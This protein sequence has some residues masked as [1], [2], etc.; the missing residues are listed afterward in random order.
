MTYDNSNSFQPHEHARTL[1]SLGGRTDSQALRSD[2]KHNRAGDFPLPGFLLYKVRSPRFDREPQ[3]IG[4]RAGGSL[5]HYSMIC[6]KNQ[7]MFAQVKIDCYYRVTTDSILVYI[8][9]EMKKALKPL[10]HN[11]FKTFSFGDP[12]EIRTPDTLI[13]SQV[14]YRLS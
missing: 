5:L 1:R 14:L 9:I 11:D 2:L 3:E 8:E 6:F 10:I 12:S 4:Y 7:A 13:K